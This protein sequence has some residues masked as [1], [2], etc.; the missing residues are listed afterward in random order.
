[1]GQTGPESS[2]QG[3][4][5]PILPYSRSIGPVE[6]SQPCCVDIVRRSQEAA[7]TT[8]DRLCTSP[9]LLYVSE[10]R[11]TLAPYCYP[12]PLGAMFSI[13]DSESSERGS[14][15]HEASPLH[16]GAGSNP[17]V[18][19]GSRESWECFLPKLTIQKGGCGNL[20]PAGTVKGEMSWGRF[21][22]FIV[23]T[24]SARTGQVNT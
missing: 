7:N 10:T 24:G 8:Q 1:M 9:V 14:N 5:G 18:F 15:L 3:N 2:K 13:L 20:L 12:G 21:G 23:G 19:N 6:L 4:M 16:K 17:M 11:D 22:A